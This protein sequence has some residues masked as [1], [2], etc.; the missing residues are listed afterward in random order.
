[1]FVSAHAP[2][3]G[4]ARHLDSAGLIAIA[5]AG[6]GVAALFVTLRCLARY[7]ELRR[8]HVDDYWMILALVILTVN[9][10]LSTLQSPSLYYLENVGV[11]NVPTGAPL[12][13][14]GNIY[15]KYEFVIIGLFWTV[16]WC[17]KA[18]F[19]ALFYRLFDGLPGYRRWWW[20]V[21]VFASLAYVGCWIASVYTCHPPS[22]YFHFG[23][24]RLLFLHRA[25]PLP[26]R[27]HWHKVLAHLG[28]LSEICSV[29]S[30]QEM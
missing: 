24:S 1:M 9:A 21:V 20:A 19:L 29:Q 7:A 11:G 22:T 28:G 8:L 23:T 27:P 17:V 6:A 18:S 30:Q 25:K 15:V 16:L 14:E 26:V 12:L 3:N 10:V 2:L 13:R 5:W 4:A